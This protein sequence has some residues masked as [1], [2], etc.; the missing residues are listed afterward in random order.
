MDIRDSK[1]RFIKGSVGNPKGRP[2]QQPTIKEL[3]QTLS[4]QAVMCLGDLIHSDNETV[5]LNASIAILNL[6]LK[7][8]QERNYEQYDDLLSEEE[9][10]QRVQRL[11][12]EADAIADL[13]LS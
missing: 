4:P 9:A 7:Y 2:K 1:G 12:E 11:F 13:D 10:R 5:A 6:S 8:G 3:L